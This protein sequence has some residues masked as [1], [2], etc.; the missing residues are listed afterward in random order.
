[1]SGH[2]STKPR[3]MEFPPVAVFYMWAEGVNPDNN[4]P[5]G[6]VVL[7]SNGRSSR[8]A[9]DVS[10]AEDLLVNYSDVLEMSGGSGYFQI[11]V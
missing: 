3:K 4:K 11:L 10:I 2:K 1:M 9:L 8:L 7:Y 6:I 5:E